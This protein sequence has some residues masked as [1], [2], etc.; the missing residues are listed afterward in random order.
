M[1]SRILANLTAVDGERRFDA[2]LGRYFAPIR[3]R[4]MITAANVIGAAPRIARVRPDLQGRIL[5]E[6]LKVSS[7]RYQTPTCRDIAIGHTLVALGEMSL[8]DKEKAKAASFAKRQLDNDRPATR[9][10][11]QEFQKRL[12]KSDQSR[13]TRKA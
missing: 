1:A 12:G 3:K 10:K 8:D 2:L 11:A 6:I 4:V 5:A 9:K 7:A 13:S